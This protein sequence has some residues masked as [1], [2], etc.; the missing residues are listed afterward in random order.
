MKTPQQIVHT[1]HIATRPVRVLSIAAGLLT[2]TSLLAAD[3]PWIS[4]FDGKTLD[5]W[6]IKGGNATYKIDGDAIVG[7][8]VERSPNTFLCRGPYGDFELQFDVLCD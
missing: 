3:G 8:T 2:A 7:T 4:L 6:T 1:L 5:G